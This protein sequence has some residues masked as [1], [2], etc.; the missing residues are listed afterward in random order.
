MNIVFG[1][2]RL[3]RIDGMGNSSYQKYTDRAVITLEGDRGAGR[4]R[5]VLFNSTAMEQMN[6]EKGE[7]QQIVFGTI[8]ADENGNRAILIANA[9]NL[10]NIDDLTTYR[11]SKNSVSFDDTKEKGKAIS[12][13]ALTKQMIGFLGL[14]ENTEVE[15]V[16]QPFDQAGLPSDSF[17]FVSLTEDVNTIE[18]VTEEVTATTVDSGVS[19]DT[20]TSG[21]SSNVGNAVSASFLTRTE[22]EPVVE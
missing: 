3:G 8:D 15:Y 1:T 16:L 19:F 20:D 18:V 22:A 4:T 5:R 14:D 7:T 9:N 6:L 13:A 12:S 17:K 10:A 11:T 2:K 21:S